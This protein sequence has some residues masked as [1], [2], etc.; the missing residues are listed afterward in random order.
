MPIDLS[1]EALRDIGDLR[2]RY[3]TSRGALL[4]TLWIA[5]RELGGL[6]A[7]A[8]EYVAKLLELPPAHV[9]ATATFY[10][11]YDKGASPEHKLQLC[12]NVSCLLGGGF[13]LLHHMERRLGIQAGETTPDGRIRLEQVECLGS[14]GTAPVLQVDDRYEEGL[15][16]DRADTILEELGVQVEG[17]ER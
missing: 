3:A 16:A 1:P 10:T 13:D 17:G 9:Y 15:T 12:T 6:S 8:M 2:K 11:M 14:C 7:D 5:Q 4:P